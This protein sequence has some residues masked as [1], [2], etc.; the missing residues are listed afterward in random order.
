VEIK[1]KREKIKV[2]D[3][4]KITCLRFSL[5]GVRRGL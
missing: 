5:R 4:I 2:G 1:V 3:K